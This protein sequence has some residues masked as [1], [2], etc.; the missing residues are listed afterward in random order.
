MIV[1]LK[2]IIMQ[3][4]LSDAV[5]ECMLRK[6]ELVSME[7]YE[8][9]KCIAGID[10]AIRLDSSPHAEEEKSGL[11]KYDC[12][13]LISIPS[14]I[15]WT[16]GVKTACDQVTWCATNFSS[17]LYL[18][19]AANATAKC[20]V[21][22]SKKRNLMLMD[23]ETPQR[24]ICE[25]SLDKIMCH[26]KSSIDGVAVCVPESLLPRSTVRAKCNCIFL[27]VFNR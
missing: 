14:D 8:E 18:T 15:F 23:C 17:E 26:M 16:S 12:D 13:F 25:V 20:T 19:G 22:V 10:D 5:R 3:V 27:F 11:F 1:A 7:T 9:M 21:L 24:F 4:S 2:N 6:M